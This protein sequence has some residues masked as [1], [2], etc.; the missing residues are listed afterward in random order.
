MCVAMGVNNVYLFM[1]YEYPPTG[2]VAT[3][4]RAASDCAVLPLASVTLRYT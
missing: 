1:G 2:T 4:M 3:V